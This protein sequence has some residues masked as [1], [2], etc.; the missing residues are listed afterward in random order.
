MATLALI[1]LWANRV[2]FTAVILFAP[3][4]LRTG[5]VGRSAVTTY[6]G[7]S[8]W[9]IAGTFVI[10]DVWHRSSFHLLWWYPVGWLAYGVLRLLLRGFFAR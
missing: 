2:F 10:P 5:R 3:A 9:Q 6:I 8:L 4:A 7:I 1:F